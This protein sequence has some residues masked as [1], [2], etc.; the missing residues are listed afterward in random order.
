MNCMTLSKLIMI[1]NWAVNLN[2]V[3]MKNE[4]NDGEIAYMAYLEAVEDTI[5]IQ[6]LKNIW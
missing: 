3:C 6:I 4:E 5:K 2:I 1:T